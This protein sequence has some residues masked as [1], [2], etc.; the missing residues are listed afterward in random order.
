MNIKLRLALLYLQNTKDG[1]CTDCVTLVIEKVW[2]ISKDC[3]N[4]KS[5]ELEDV[6]VSFFFSCRTFFASLMQYAMISRTNNIHSSLL[7][8]VLLAGDLFCQA[9]NIKTNG[10]VMAPAVRKIG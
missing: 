8:P 10:M 1:H 6:A 4:K 3:T 9:K 2:Y 7:G 5:S